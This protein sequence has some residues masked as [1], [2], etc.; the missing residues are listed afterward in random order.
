MYYYEVAPTQ[1]VRSG[2]DSFT[3]ASN[4]Q[5]TPGQVVRV[6]VGKKLMNGLVLHSTGEPSYATKSIEHVL[7]ATPIPVAYIGLAQ[8]VSAYYA[9]PLATVLQ[10]LLPSGVHKNRRPKVRTQ[11]VSVRERTQYVLNEDQA[12]AVQKIEQSKP[13][14]VLLH[15]VT[16]SGKTAVYIELARREI[17]AGKSVIILVPEIALTSQLVAEFSQHFDDILLTHSKQSEAERHDIWRTALTSDHPR[18]I[19]G[20]RS[21]LFL[22]VKDIGLIVI[23]EAHEPSYKQEQSPRYHALRAAHFLAESSGATLVLGSATPSI[24]DRYLAESTGRPVIV[25]D[26]RAVPGAHKPA[27]QIVDMTKRTHFKRHR[28]LSDTVLSQIEQD[29]SSGKQVLLFHNRRG[30]APTTLCENCGWQAG[31]P[32]C[33]VPLTLHADKHELRCHICNFTVHVPTS[34]PE[35]NHASIIH[36]GIGTK[37]I[38]SE[39]TRLFPKLTIARFDGDASSDETVEARYAQ[40]YDGTIDVIIGTQVIAKGLD[41]PKLHTVAVVQADAG[42]SLPDYISAERTFQLLAQVVGRVGRTSA[43]TNVIVQSYQPTHPAITL[44]L[45]QDYASFYDLAVQQR[46]RSHFPPFTYLLKLQCSYK[47]EAAAI[48]N[49]KKFAEQLKSSLPSDV[50]ILGPTPAFYERAGGSYRWQLILKSPKR[51]HLTE[52]LGLLPPK[53]WQFELDPMSLL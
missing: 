50:Q 20:P 48:R 29:T 8:W 30:S 14:T 39:L 42:L 19:V 25:M 26:K 34:C 33:F 3:Y 18:V 12:A 51:S 10:T 38:E 4:E 2:T 49:A 16:G 15:G 52:A 37:L 17:N 41:L 11:S 22:P 35:C 44:G 53:N 6:S 45:N 21:A 27:I 43:D 5:L 7:E 24:V 47:T 31:C 46:K 36:K 1:I 13:G 9:T 23:D 28:F 32:R 40:L